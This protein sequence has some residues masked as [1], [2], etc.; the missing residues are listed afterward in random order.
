MVDID[1]NNQ[2]HN[3]SPGWY[4]DDVGIREGKRWVNN[5]EDWEGSITGWASRRGLWQMGV[6]TSGPGAAHSGE[7]CWA[8][9][10]DGNYGLYSQSNLQSVW[11]D[12]PLDPPVQF[13][14]WHWFSFST[15]DGTDYGNITVSHDGGYSVETDNFT[16]SSGGWTQYILDLSAFAGQ[17][18]QIWFN[19][20][21][22]DGGNQGSSESSG[23]YLDDFTFLGMDSSSPST[24]VLMD[25]SYSTGA[26]IIE[27]FAITTE[28]E[29]VCIYATKDADAIVDLSNRVA[30]LPADGVS[31]FVDIERPGWGKY[32]YWIS[33]VDSFGHE[34]LIIGPELSG[35]Y[36]PLEIPSPFKVVLHGSHPNPFN[37]KAELSFTISEPAHVV[38]EVFDIQG[39]L[40]SRLLDEPIQS[41]KHTVPFESRRLASGTYL[42]RLQVGDEVKTCKMMLT[43]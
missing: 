1:G 20:F 16:G 11:I 23:W 17:P 21:D 12:L 14:F 36:D 10:L 18:V 15:S 32:Y 43:K 26:P 38:L 28:F 19:V 2:G 37:P 34:G 8:T 35:V 30:V 29:K 39:R 25:V 41:G 6:P 24:P 31:S 40:V 3:E 7:R 13:S 33:G 27:Y 22:V 4:I 5:V 42:A 9:R